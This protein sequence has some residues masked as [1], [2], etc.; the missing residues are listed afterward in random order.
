MAFLITK[1]L[2]AY[3]VHINVMYVLN[4]LIS[5]YPA[6]EPIGWNGLNK[7]LIVVA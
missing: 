2:I 4:N 6:M 7:T 1:Y 5:V 3:N